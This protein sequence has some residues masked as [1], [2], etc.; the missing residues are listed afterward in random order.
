MPP[1]PNPYL[2]T[3]LPPSHYPLVPPVAGPLHSVPYRGRPASTWV[4]KLQVH[5]EV[6][7]SSLNRLQTYSCK[8][9]QLRSG[10]LIPPNPRLVCACA[11]RIGGRAHKLASR[12][13]PGRLVKT[14]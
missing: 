12:C 11:S 6:Q 10:G 1:I 14:L 9:R 5:A 2:A 8:R 4:A 3:P 7:D 13:A